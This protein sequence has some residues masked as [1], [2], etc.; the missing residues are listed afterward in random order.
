[1]KVS[2]FITIAKLNINIG[3]KIQSK[4]IWLMTHNVSAIK[5]EFYSGMSIQFFIVK[6]VG[7]FMPGYKCCLYKR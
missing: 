5:Q 7:A 2:L 1:M 6:K 3:I 4:F